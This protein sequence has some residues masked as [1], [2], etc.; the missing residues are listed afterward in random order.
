MY[1]FLLSCLGLGLYFLKIICLYFLISVSILINAYRYNEFGQPVC[2][3]CDVALK[4]ESLWD[5]HQV[6]RKHREVIIFTIS[7]MLC[8]TGYIF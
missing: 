8:T 5:A 1:L 2:R 6:S 3:V 7:I 4:S